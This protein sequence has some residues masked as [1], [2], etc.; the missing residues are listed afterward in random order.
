VSID[1]VV[2][3]KTQSH[4]STG[5]DAFR[6]LQEVEAPKISRHSA[7][8][9][10]KVTSPTYRPPLPVRENPS[11]LFLLDAESTAGSQ[12]GLKNEVNEKSERPQR[13]SNSRPFGL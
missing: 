7:H 8:E 10:S 9:G 3:G 5:L 4:S 6:G 13:E 2:N 12:C 11:Y 1:Y